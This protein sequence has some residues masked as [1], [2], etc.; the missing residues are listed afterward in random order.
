[1]PNPEWSSLH[2]STKG[3]VVIIPD[4]ASFNAQSHD[5]ASFNAHST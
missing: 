2:R 1:M 3:V 4:S 5:P